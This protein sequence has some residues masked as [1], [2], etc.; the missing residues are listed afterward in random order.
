MT[1][2][3]RRALLAFTGSLMTLLLALFLAHPELRRDPQRPATLELLGPWLASHPADWL[4]A[5]AISDQALDYD[6]PRRVELWRAAYVHAEY[7]APLRPNGA[8]GFVRAGLFHWYELKEADRKSVLEVAAPLLR[9]PRVFTALYGPLW[10]LTKD[11]GYLRRVA[12]GTTNAAGQ[13]RDLAVTNG[14]FEDYRQLRA[15]VRARRLRD[16]H[17]RRD[18]LTPPE[19][20][21]LLPEHVDTADEPLVRAMLEHLDRSAFEVRQLGGNAEKLARYALDHHVGPLSALATFCE[22]PGVIGDATRA[23][24]ALALGRRDAA[25]RIE[26]S[27]AVVTAAKEWLP[28]YEERAELEAREGNAEAA[29]SY[30][31]Q[32]AAA[33]QASCGWS[34]TCGQNELCVFAS[35]ET[36]G[37]LAF[38]LAVLQSDETPPYVEVYVDDL[39]VSE[40]PV[41]DSRKLTV[42]GP[43]WHR[44][45]LRLAN[46]HTRNGVQRLLRLS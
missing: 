9:D 11:L 40:G 7:L 4:A 27:G 30:R 46:R 33:R 41:A 20:I 28:Y 34:S 42:G 37:P 1:R 13:L 17:E 12:P 43:G 23:R 35:R 25:T 36:N 2:T 31:A 10:Q 45:E 5:T 38:E 15:V 21:A 32:A 3:M 29:A 39:L 14:R 26:M 6:S 8:A 18:S 16:L 44:V 19:L 24:L 22:T